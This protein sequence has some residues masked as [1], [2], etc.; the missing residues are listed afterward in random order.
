MVTDHLASVEVR[1]TGIG[2]VNP[3]GF[4]PEEFHEALCAGKSGVQK[5]MSSD[6]V[7]ISVAQVRGFPKLWETPWFSDLPPLAHYAIRAGKEAL[8]NAGL[9][10]ETPKPLRLG[11]ILATSHGLLETDYRI[12]QT[13]SGIGPHAVSPLTALLSGKDVLTHLCAIHLGVTAFTRTI[14]G[15][16]CSSLQAVNL[17]RITLATG[18]ADMVLVGGADAV[19]DFLARFLRNAGMTSPGGECRPYEKNANG[20]VLGEG[21]AFLV[22]ETA[23]GAERRGVSGLARVI[24]C[25]LDSDLSMDVTAG[26]E[27]VLATLIGDLF[28]PTEPNRHTTVIY[29]NGC[30]EPRLDD[31]EK[32]ALE[33]VFRSDLSELALTAPKAQTGDCGSVS[34]LFHLISACRY[35]AEGTFPCLYA[36]SADRRCLVTACETGGNVGGLLL[37]QVR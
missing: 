6:G 16:A 17:A 34:G 18:K 27:P 2:L 33:T 8:R 36:A 37:E 35:L 30:G 19:P 21:A 12:Y 1:I 11:L 10:R 28:A 9:D 13:M 23:T 22:M 32:T 14:V 4:T 7:E 5:V 15:G 26:K 20:L 3:L 25:N 24:D 29:G 31:Y